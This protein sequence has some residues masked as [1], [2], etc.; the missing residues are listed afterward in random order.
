MLFSKIYNRTNNFGIKNKS[1]VDFNL[2]SWKL[3]KQ[4]A[5]SAAKIV[6]QLPNPTKQN[7][8]TEVLSKPKSPKDYKDRQVNEYEQA[9]MYFDNYS[10][11]NSKVKNMDKPDGVQ[12]NIKMDGSAKKTM[13]V[14]TAKRAEKKNVKKT[15]K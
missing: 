10:D 12:N 8:S 13:D 15:I 1:N 2:S 11:F 3:R 4:N 5:S 14:R 6:E 7:L 9:P